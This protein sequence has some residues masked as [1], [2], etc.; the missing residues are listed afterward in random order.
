MIRITVIIGT[1]IGT[2]RMDLLISYSQL[3]SH[4]NYV[5]INCNPK[6]IVV[7][8]D[9]IATL[10]FW[11]SAPAGCLRVPGP[12]GRVGPSEGSERA[13]R[14]RGAQPPKTFSRFSLGSA[15]FLKATIS[16]FFDV[17]G[18]FSGKCKWS[19]RIGEKSL[20]F[21]VSS[22]APLENAVFSWVPSEGT[23]PTLEWALANEHR[24][25]LRGAAPEEIVGFAQ[26]SACF[27]KAVICNFWELKGFISRG[28]KTSF[29]GEQI[30]TS[31]ATNIRNRLT[32]SGTGS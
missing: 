5:I 3:W 11:V 20:C 21:K 30:V 25:G 12:P 7:F 6:L 26:E 1:W 8:V 2:R 4:C 14:G 16:N 15:C 29:S 10:S 24:A 19:L 18:M 28:A 9:L 23:Y 17:A 13:R 27:L 32:R 31:N 22:A